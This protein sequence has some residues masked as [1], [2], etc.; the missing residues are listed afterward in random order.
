MNNFRRMPNISEVFEPITQ[1]E[2]IAH[3]KEYKHAKYDLDAMI[4]YRERDKKYNKHYSWYGGEIFGDHHV[5]R[6]QRYVDKLIAV[7]PN[8]K[9]P[10]LYPNTICTIK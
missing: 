5:E 6:Q 4:E 1:S 7:R 2:K 8:W 10:K 9:P 3:T